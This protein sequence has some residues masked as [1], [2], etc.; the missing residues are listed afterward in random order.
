MAPEDEAAFLGFVLERPTVHLIPEVRSPTPRVPHTRDLR[1][2]SSLHCMLWDTAILPQP[3]VEYIPSC[4]DY[5]L[6]SDE[7]L[8]Q[9][10]RSPVSGSSIGAGRI[11]LA[12]SGKGAPSTNPKTARAMT[13]WYNA[14][15]RLIKANFKNSFVYASDFKPE[16]GRR[17]RAVWVGP[18]AIEMSAQGLK[19]KDLGPPEYS[20]HYFDPAEADRLLARYRDPRAI[21]GVG[22]VAHV[23][24]RVDPMMRKQR[25]RVTIEHGAPFSEF[26]GVFMCLEPE[27]KLGDEVACVFT[28]NIL[29]RHAEPWEPR[30]IKRL[31]PARRDRILE[32]LRRSLR[33]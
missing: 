9:F 2:L 30:E 27:P 5:Y 14:L 4:D 11:A 24:E 20:L 8:I 32:G 26:E 13:T 28:E 7:S 19:L 33:L 23:G 12:T 31:T 16:V 25:F 3:E 22:R 29:G 10:L 18:S 21:I 6:G 1:E 17:V 15:S